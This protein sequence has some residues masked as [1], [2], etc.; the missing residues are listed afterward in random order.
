MKHDRI[1]CGVP[2][3]AWV[4]YDQAADWCAAR[5]SKG[6]IGDP[7]PDLLSV[8]AHHLINADPEAFADRVRSCAYARAMNAHG[9]PV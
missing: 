2:D 1:C 6:E 5:G 3:R 9:W 4:E 8:E 7:L